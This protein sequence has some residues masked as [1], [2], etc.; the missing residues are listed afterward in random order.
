MPDAADKANSPL[1]II[2][3]E[4]EFTVKRRARQC[5]RQWL[6]ELP[7]ADQEII[8]GNAANSGEAL[9]AIAK[10]REALQTLPFFGT[11]KIVWFQNCN[12]FGEERTATSQAVTEALSGLAAELKGFVW[13]DVRLL[14]SSGKIDKRRTFYKTIEKLGNIELYSGWSLDDR[15]WV[16]Q[17]EGWAR[18]ELNA[19]QKAIS[20]E[21]LA[22]LVTLCG[23][24]G[25][26]DQH[27]IAFDAVQRLAARNL[28]FVNELE[29][30]IGLQLR[31]QHAVH[32]QRLVRVF[33]GI[34]SRFG[35]VHLVKRNLVRALAT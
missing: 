7:D 14:I 2:C 15:D 20:Q 25:C 18:K 16:G 17:A 26:V 29:L 3:G 34:L 35:N 27:A 31:P 32:V 30:V 24:R 21:A 10:L 5:H 1:W 33:A 4:D 28:Q 6:S 12:F 22:Q 8:D 23:E 9:R 13:M 19:A 11:G